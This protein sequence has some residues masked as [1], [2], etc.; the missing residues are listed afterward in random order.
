MFYRLLYSCLSGCASQQFVRLDRLLD[1]SL[2]GSQQTVRLCRLLQLS[3][4]EAI[5]LLSLNTS[6]RSD[7]V[8]LHSN[9]PG[10]TGF[11]LAVRKVVQAATLQSVRWCRLLQAVCKLC[12]I[13]RNTLPGCAGIYTAVCL[14]VQAAIV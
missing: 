13:L 7:C 2:S 10:R 1:S 4:Q 9:L 11:F 5:R 8:L 6:R 14:V 3:M 12:R